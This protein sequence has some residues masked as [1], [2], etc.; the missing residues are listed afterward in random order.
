MTH[1]LI[2]R[3]LAALL[4][5]VSLAAS[6]QDTSWRSANDT[7]GQ[8]RRGHIDIIR[9][10]PPRPEAPSPAR[11][12]APL[13]AAEALDAALLRHPDLWLDPAATPM[14]RL[15]AQRKLAELDLSVLQAWIG[16]VTAERLMAIEQRKLIAARS[17]AELAQ[18]MAAI[19]NWPAARAATWQLGLAA[20]EQSHREQS[21][22][23]LQARLALSALTGLPADRALPEA[24]PDMTSAAARPDAP[25][26]D[27]QL[28][29]VLGK[30]P[31]WLAL[32][33][34]LARDEQ[35]LA[36]PANQSLL[37]ALE[38]AAPKAQAAGSSLPVLGREA[39]V[40]AAGLPMAPHAIKEARER[41]ETARALRLQA[42]H[43]LHLSQQWQQ[44]TREQWQR[45]RERQLPL[46]TQI[47]EETVRLY[48]G[49]FA[50]TWDVI[51]QTDARLSLEQALVQ[52]EAAVWMADLA[53]QA[54]LAGL[55]WTPPAM[56][57]AAPAAGADPKGH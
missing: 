36:R 45:L 9:A 11:T 49:M 8:F 31:E 50:S 33:A 41:V 51:S 21:L 40:R 52:A 24:L 19:G 32:Q 25:S 6:A 16:A 43:E 3:T 17:A 57:A 23:V 7:V 56:A 10:M 28:D 4:G 53:H 14:A 39:P 13:Q 37:N 42:H 54:L 27:A 38:T 15:E 22:A 5:G 20:A 30:R 2:A 44:A 48:N 26:I 55:P 34:N 47:S 18:R 29:Q 1:T 35:L 46:Q 12:G